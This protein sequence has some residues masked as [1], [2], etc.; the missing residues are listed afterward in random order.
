MVEPISLLFFFTLHLSVVTSAKFTIVNQ[1]NYTVWPANS[2]T[3]SGNATTATTGF[4]LKPGEN[5]TITL[6]AKWS[7]RIWGRTLCTTNSTTGNFSCVT[8]DCGSG[9]LACVGKSGS[10]PMTEAEFT[11]NGLNDQD[12]YDVNLIDGYNL[13]MDVI[14]LDGS[15]KCK[16]T[17]CPT[18]LNTVCPTELQVTE[19]GTVVACQSPCAAFN[20]QFFCCAGK[21]SSSENCEPSVYSKI[22]KTTCP[23]AYSY[24]YDDK[25]SAFTCPAT[26][27][28]VVFCP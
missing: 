6:P 4:I 20:L 12:F 14:P 19:N 9:K 10:P 24:A 17:G 27:Y 26:D 1:C 5:S 21:Y 25:T 16:S 22:F 7:G 18:D 2:Y 3:T 28:Q 15:G 13:P 8:G 23:Q 11:L